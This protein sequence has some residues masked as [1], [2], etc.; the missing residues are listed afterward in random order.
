MCFFAHALRSLN[1]N[2]DKDGIV[3]GRIASAFAPITVGE[4]AV[5]LDVE[6]GRNED[7][8]DAAV[9][10]PVVFETVE[11]AVLSESD[12]SAFVGILQKP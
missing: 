2:F 10:P 6:A 4:N 1:R 12:A 3:I 7:V 9:G 5:C 8:V 11:G